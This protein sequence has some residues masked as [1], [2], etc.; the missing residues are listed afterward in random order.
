MLSVQSAAAPA[1]T[2]SGF[3]CL[4]RNTQAPSRNRSPA[5]IVPLSISRIFPGPVVDVL[6]GQKIAFTE[7]QVRRSPLSGRT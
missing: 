5:A 1:Q 4:S 3:Q 7:G 2:Y 6:L